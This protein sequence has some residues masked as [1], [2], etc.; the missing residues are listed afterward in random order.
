MNSTKSPRRAGAINGSIAL[1]ACLAL[2]VPLALAGC[3][4]SSATPSLGAGASPTIGPTATLGAS[5]SAMATAVPSATPDATIAPTSTPNETIT[6]Q[7]L[8][9]YFTGAMPNATMLKD[10]GGVIYWDYGGSIGK[11]YNP[12]TLIQAALAYY[13]RWLVDSDPAQAESD[14]T[15]F[16][17]Q[18]NWLI[19]H[20]TPDGRWLYTF[21]WGS[22]PLPWWSAMAEGEAM[23][24]LLRAYL[25]TG[26]PACLTAIERARSTFE[27][28]LTDNGVELSVALGS[29]TYVVYQEYL[30]GYQAN[31]LNGWIFSL[32]GL[33]ETATYLGDSSAYFD[34]WGPDRG[35]AAL[36]ALL[37]Y[38]DTGSWSF[39]NMVNPGKS[40]SGSLDSTAYHQLVIFQLRYLATISGDPFFSQYADRFQSYL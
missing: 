27:R 39:Y 5:P 10:S 25:M 8:P 6:L 22:Q 23:S 40:V 21:R 3:G 35:L 36:K 38:Y 26:D 30:T 37:P 11:Q 16:L 19:S 24:A 14:K 18:I 17:T 20:Q 13:N 32:V 33:Y 2:A 4:S 31:V 34:F 15:A 7:A 9:A 1:A 12:V 28:D 29:D